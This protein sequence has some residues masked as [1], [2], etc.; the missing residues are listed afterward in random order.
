MLRH[1]RRVIP[2]LAM[3]VIAG[4]CSHQQVTFHNH[5]N[6]RITVGA[7]VPNPPVYPR[8]IFGRGALNS[9]YWTDIQAGTSWT[10]TSQRDLADSSSLGGYYKSMIVYVG[11]GNDWY[12]V[13]IGESVPRDVRVHMAGDKLAVSLASGRTMTL[14]DS[15]YQKAYERVRRRR[16]WMGRAAAQSDTE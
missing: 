6:K 8:T 3:A 2:H 12:E 9:H 5:L 10:T 1:L 4:G 13:D 7:T 16:D 14:E 11:V 15:T